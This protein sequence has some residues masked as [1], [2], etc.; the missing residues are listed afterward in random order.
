MSAEDEDAARAIRIA[1]TIAPLLA[2]EGPRVQSMIIAALAATWVC[3]HQPAHLRGDLVESFAIGLHGLV[4]R[5]SGG[6]DPRH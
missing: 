5:M 4:E 1:N 2:G 3:G 6:E